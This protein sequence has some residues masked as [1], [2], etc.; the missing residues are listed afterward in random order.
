MPALRRIGDRA[1]L[2]NAD[3]RAV[4]S[5]ASDIDAGDLTAPEEPC[6]RYRVG[7]TFTVWSDATG[8]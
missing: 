2:V 4:A 6:R 3:G 5:A 7:R 8:L 1:T